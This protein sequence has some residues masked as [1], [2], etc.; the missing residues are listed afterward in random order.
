[1]SI[2]IIHYREQVGTMTTR[3]TEI[4]RPHHAFSLD[5]IDLQE[6]EF[7]EEHE[8]NLYRVTSLHVYPHPLAA[9]VAHQ[10]ANMVLDTD[11]YSDLF[12]DTDLIGI[13]TH[14]TS[15]LLAKLREYNQTQRADRRA[16]P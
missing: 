14:L 15:Q 5:G 8:E 9:S 12:V 6:G 10:Y 1:M 4:V 2:G 3:T 11:R 7:T 16:L 13:R